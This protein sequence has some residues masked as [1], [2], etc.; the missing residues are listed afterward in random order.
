VDSPAIDFAVD[1]NRLFT[2][3]ASDVVIRATG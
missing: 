2:I 1:V 3:E